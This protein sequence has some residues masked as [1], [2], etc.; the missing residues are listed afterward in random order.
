[1]LCPLCNKEIGPARNRL[2]HMKKDH[3]EQFKEAMESLRGARRAGAQARREEAQERKRGNGTG[4]SHKALS[5]ISTATVPAPG[6]IVFTLGQQKIEIDPGDL[7]ECWML[8]MD[9]KRLLPLKDEFTTILRDCV[10]VTYRQVMAQVV[11]FEGGVSVV[12]AQAPAE[13]GN[14]E[15]APD[16]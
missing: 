16:G 3:P 11:I 6:A 7:I 5:P 14:S 2:G 13:N 15:E 8:C 12:K 1:M 4:Q 10:D 9:M